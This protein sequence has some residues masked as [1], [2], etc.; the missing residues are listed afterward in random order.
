MAAAAGG[1]QL[2]ALPDDLLV[3]A[4]SFLGRCISICF[5]HTAGNSLH[6]RSP[7]CV[8]CDTAPPAL[9]NTLIYSKQNK[10]LMRTCALIAGPRTSPA[11][12][13]SARHRM[14]H[15]ALPAGRA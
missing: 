14:L 13:L 11:S 4:A 7:C 15:S 5:T 6:C 8:G 12:G 2:D 10:R 9:P 3:H 1:L